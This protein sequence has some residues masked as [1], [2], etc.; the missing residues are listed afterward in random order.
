MRRLREC[1]MIA[2]LAAIGAIL[3]VPIAG[4]GQDATVSGTVTDS[5]SAVIPGVTV[6]AT[7]LESGN[8]FVAVTDERGG[9]RLPLRVGNYRMTAELPGFG[10]VNRGFRC[11]S[12]RSPSSISR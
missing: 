12:G 3:M 7:H 4:Y 9:Y 10:T 2:L 8:K 5:T 11:S 1:Y 6:T